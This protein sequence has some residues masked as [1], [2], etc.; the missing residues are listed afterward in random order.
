M[1]EKYSCN[2]MISLVQ[3]IIVEGT[4]EILLAT[5]LIGSTTLIQKTLL[6]AIQHF[7]QGMNEANALILIKDYLSKSKFLW[8]ELEYQE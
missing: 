8:R 2:R 4:D 6:S 7:R 3:N 5:H 1:N